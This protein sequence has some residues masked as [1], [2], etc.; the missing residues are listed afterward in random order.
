MATPQS[1]SSQPVEVGRKSEP[2][3]IVMGGLGP[4]LDDICR[5][6]ES[7]GRGVLCSVYLRTGEELSLAAAPGF[8]AETTR[9]LH[10]DQQDGQLTRPVL[11]AQGE[12]LGLISLHY[13]DGQL[14]APGDRELLHSASRLVGI[15]IAARHDALTGLPTRTHFMDRLD[16]ILWTDPRRASATAVLAM[17]LDRFQQIN[18]S[19]GRTAG[20]GLLQEAGRRLTGLLCGEDVAGR[21]AADE[22]AVVITGLAD[23]AQALQR[24]NAFLEA[25]RAPYR[26]DGAELFVTASIGLVILSGQRN[27]EELLR[28]AE[29]AMHGAKRN[30]RNTLEVFQP[31][32]HARGM[33]RLQLQNALHRAIENRELDLL[34]QP[35]VSMQGKVQGFEAL[36]TWHHPI[37]GVVPPS[38]F[39]PIAEESG[40][41]AELGAWVLQQACLAGARWHQ[42]GHCEACLSVN[43][44]AREFERESFVNGLASVLAVSGFPPERLEL[45]LTE[46]SV[47]RDLS[48]SAQRMAAIRELGVRIAIDDFGTGY[49]SLSY[50]SKLPV[51]SLKLDQSFL[52]EV[53]A[54]GGAMVLIQSVVRL[55]HGMNLTVV[56]EG[57]ETG[58]QLDLVKVVGCD[59]AQGIFCGQPM[60][61][62]QVAELLA[63]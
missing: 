6:V 15:A 12:L 57:V 29:L 3:R 8:A 11:S 31:E 44:S 39:I 24:A 2:A 45:E 21:L 55:A 18:D 17:D 42:A 52:R 41:I 16:A 59:L 34:Y 14:E 58:D 28:D 4:I 61:A 63:R 25:M 30:G 51:D 13:Q 62:D 23:E 50:L 19:L 5:M 27:A 22:F 49:S 56:A 9:S 10:P 7:R 40:F 35:L 46:S 60:R 1:E 47:L 38:E 43:V 53:G 37:H 48:K 32:K 20:D 26:I 54:D 36:L 33:A